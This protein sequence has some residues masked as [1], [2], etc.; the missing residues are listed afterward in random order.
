M[1][2]ISTMSSG[3]WR[4]LSQHGRLPHRAGLSEVPESIWRVPVKSDGLSKE[5]VSFGW[6]QDTC[7]C[8]ER[9]RY[10][11]HHPTAYFLLDIKAFC[12]FEEHHSSSLCPKS[13]KFPSQINYLIPCSNSNI[14]NTSKESKKKN[15]QMG[16]FGVSHY[17][18]QKNNEVLSKALCSS[19]ST[20]FLH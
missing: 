17:H 3:L 6:Y 14:Q 15:P 19:R 9:S 16:G 13:K 7:A 5:A 2:L 11:Q 10:L 1:C 20:S 4:S 18:H 12:A 8:T